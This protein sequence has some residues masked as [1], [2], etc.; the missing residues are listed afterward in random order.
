M[1]MKEFHF[2]IATIESPARPDRS[3]TS[4]AALPSALRKQVPA[5]KRSGD[6]PALER[7]P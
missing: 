7:D 4:S 5:R 3:R 6:L 2:K 1:R